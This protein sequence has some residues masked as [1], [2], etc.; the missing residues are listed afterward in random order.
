[1]RLPPLDHL[2][3]DIPKRGRWVPEYT[4]NAVPLKKLGAP[5]NVGRMIAYLSSPAAEFITGSDS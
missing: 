5:E 1:M 3:D 4:L 2:Q